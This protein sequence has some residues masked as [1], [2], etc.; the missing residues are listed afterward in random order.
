MSGNRARSVPALA[1]WPRTRSA[2]QR[3]AV[4]VICHSG[5]MAPNHRLQLSGNLVQEQ[6]AD[7][8]IL[9]RPDDW[10]AEVDLA[11]VRFPLPGH[12]LASATSVLAR[13]F[14][15]R[16]DLLAGGPPDAGLIPPRYLSMSRMLSDGSGCMQRLGT[17]WR[18]I[19]RW[20]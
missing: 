2:A 20:R 15:L 16:I 17:F 9:E 5:I 1:F 8:A 18:T 3:S 7:S 14:A 6:D 13:A 10:V 4:S 19:L 11:F 12:I